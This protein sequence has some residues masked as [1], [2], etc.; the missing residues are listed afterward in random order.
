MLQEIFLAL[1]GITGD[2]IVEENSTLKVKDDCHLL[3]ESRQCQVDSLVPLGWYYLRFGEIVNA[4]EANFANSVTDSCFQMYR[5]AMI[6]GVSDLMLEYENDVA[7]LEQ[8]VLVEG[9][10]PL[11]HVLQHFQKVCLQLANMCVKI[12]LLTQAVAVCIGVS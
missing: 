2:I 7:N 8:S 10:V 5:A 11:S 3:G 1:V 4:H 9:D 12:L 6:R